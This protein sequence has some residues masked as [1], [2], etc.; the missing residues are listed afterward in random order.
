VIKYLEDRRLFANWIM[1]ISSVIKQ[2]VVVFK[3]ICFLV[4]TYKM[5]LKLCVILTKAKN[6]QKLYCCTYEGEH[7]VIYFEELS[8]HSTC[9]CSNSLIKKIIGVDKPEVV[10]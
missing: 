1:L 3:G 10:L 8:E 6:K 9:L 4:G 7:L 5:K 2:L